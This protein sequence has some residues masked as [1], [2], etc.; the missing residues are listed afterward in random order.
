MQVILH[1]YILTITLL[2]KNLKIVYLKVQV[3]VVQSIVSLMS[4]LR[5]QLVKCLINTDIFIEKSF[6]IFFN[7]KNWIISG[8]NVRNFNETLTND[9]VSFEPDPDNLLS[10]SSFDI[11]KASHIF[12]TKNGLFQ[13]LTFEMISNR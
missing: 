3:P 7:K 9:V 5:G 11:A 2:I 12:S 6:S 10:I 8:F 13:I 1:D 4:S